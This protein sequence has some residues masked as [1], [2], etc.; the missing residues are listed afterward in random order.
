MTLEF[1][2]RKTL[3]DIDLSTWARVKHFATM[4]KISVNNAVQLLLIIGLGNF[5]YNISQKQMTPTGESL[6]AST[7]N[8]SSL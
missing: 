7:Q 2:K 5:G 8:A 4:R 1:T 6:V 3:V